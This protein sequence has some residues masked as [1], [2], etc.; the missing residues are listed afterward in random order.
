M[1][2]KIN[3]DYDDKVLEGIILTLSPSFIEI[4]MTSPFNGICKYVDLEKDDNLRPL[5]WPQIE[6]DFSDLSCFCDDK[7]ITSFGINISQ[8]ILKDIYD[9]CNSI[10]LNLHIFKDDIVRLQNFY[11]GAD[12]KSLGFTHNQK[13]IAEKMNSEGITVDFLKAQISEFESDIQ[14]W[15][16]HYFSRERHS[17]SIRFSRLIEFS[18]DIL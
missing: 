12:Y 6:P 8:N 11:N 14:K 2:L 7:G 16:K 10:F 13:K 1:E 4:K 3:V 15:F 17:D 18:F 5:N 9:V